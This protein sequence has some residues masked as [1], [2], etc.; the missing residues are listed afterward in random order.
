MISSRRLKELRGNSAKMAI[1]ACLG[2]MRS[3]TLSLMYV[4]NAKRC[5]PCAEMMAFE[6]FIR[7]EDSIIRSSAAEILVKVAPEIVVKAALEAST[8]AEVSPF[9]A[10]LEDAGYKE[11]D[12][13]TTLLHQESFVVERV[14][15]TFV[16]L[17]RADLLFGLAVSGDEKTTERVKR[18]LHEQ[19]FI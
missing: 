17:G 3:G 19:G 5:A 10:A 16:T 7:H 12:D 14:F 8:L 1:E 9:L 15:Q 13:L 2:S 6:E 18:Y 4:R 11:I